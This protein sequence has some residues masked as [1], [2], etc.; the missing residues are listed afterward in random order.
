MTEDNGNANANANEFVIVHNEAD[1]RTDWLLTT[2]RN[3]TGKAAQWVSV[4]QRAQREAQEI[5]KRIMAENE[6]KDEESDSESES[7]AMGPKSKKRKRLA[8]A[9][10]INDETIQ[11]L[12][13]ARNDEL[14]SS[15]ANGFEINAN[16]LSNA[17]DEDG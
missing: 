3:E 4:L 5:A 11:E 10:V 14:H 9:R 8:L 7:V 13:T 2:E 1:S 16:S 12:E 17:N 6:E 15:L